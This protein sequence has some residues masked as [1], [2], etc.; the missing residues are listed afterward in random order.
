MSDFESNVMVICLK[1]LFLNIFLQVTYAEPGF[2]K[3]KFPPSCD[4]GITG[5]RVYVDA[6]NRGMWES[7]ER[8][9]PLSDFLLHLQ[10]LLLKKLL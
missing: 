6:C 4:T 2:V 10:F 3:L 9:I 8:C 1:L 5:S 7:L